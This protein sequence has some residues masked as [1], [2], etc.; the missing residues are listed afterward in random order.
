MGVNQDCPCGHT[1]NFHECAEG[2]WG[3]GKH[4]VQSAFVLRVVLWSLQQ[5]V[6]SLLL[7]LLRVPPREHSGVGYQLLC[8]AVG[9]APTMRQHLLGAQWTLCLSPWDLL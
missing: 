4:A 2:W 3:L 5:E 8:D 9:C 7:Y 6:L 1:D